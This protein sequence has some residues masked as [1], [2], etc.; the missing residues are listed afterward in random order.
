MEYLKFI[1]NA[2]PNSQLFGGKGS[3]LIKLHNFGIEIP[4]G[5]IITT[6]FYKEV[7][8]Y[9][10]LKEKLS[11]VFSNNLLPKKIIEFSNEIKD[12]FLNIEFSNKILYELQIAFDEI[13]NNSDQNISFAVRSSAN[14]EDQKEFSFAGQAESYLCVRDLDDVIKALKSCLSSLYSPQALLYLYQ[15]RKKKKIIDF[16]KL[17]LAIIIQKMINAQVSGV[18]FTINVINN[19][20]NQ[21]LINSAWGLG[22]TVTGNKIIPDLIIIDKRNGKIEKYII[23]EKHLTSIPN[24]NGKSTILIETNENLRMKCSITREQIQGL[25]DLGL[26]IEKKFKYPQDI[27]WAIENTEI[28]T[29]QTRPI[30]TL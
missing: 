5:F 3:N 25:Y 30:T 14:I 21:M 23:G 29:L 10:P 9:T 16:R 19:N 7:L 6:K 22:D 2:T 20:R 28:Y 13:L 18:L 15:M 4:P 11:K 12:T 24:S 26:K 8:K 17:K 27:E 1:N